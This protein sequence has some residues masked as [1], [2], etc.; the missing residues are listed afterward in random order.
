MRMRSIMAVAILC[1]CMCLCPAVANARLAISG[2]DGKQL[3]KGE[4]GT[5]TPDSVSVIDL[6]AYPPKVVGQVQVPAA[7]IGPPEAVA[8][9]RDESFAIVTA[10]Q[11]YDPAD[12]MHPLD[13]DQ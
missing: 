11:K 6:N 10:A 8:V 7:M 2:N 13:N 12:P 4:D 3:Q 9:S 5:V 1:P